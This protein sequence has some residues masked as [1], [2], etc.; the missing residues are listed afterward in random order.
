MG[1]AEQGY[2]FCVECQRKKIARNVGNDEDTI[3]EICILNSFFFVLHSVIFSALYGMALDLLAQFYLASNRLKEAE[4]L[5]VEA[6]KCGRLVYGEEGDQVLVVTNSLATVVSMQAGREAEAADMMEEVV[7][8]ASRTSS[9][10]LT[11]FLINLG[12]VRM[13]Q[14][15]VD[16]A[17]ARCEGAR[18]LAA[19]GGDKEAEQEADNCLKELETLSLS[20][21]SGAAK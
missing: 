19:S 13:K 7:R 5:W 2:I 21:S 4:S 1:K 18:R 8:T 3:G 10:H 11:A 9:P 17:R 16:E 6:V 12:L 15:L 14:G 20:R